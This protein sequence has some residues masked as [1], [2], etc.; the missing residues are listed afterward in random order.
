M[1][2][3]KQ[4][5]LFPIMLNNGLYYVGQWLL[6]NEEIKDCETIKLEFNL[7]NNFTFLGC[8][9]VTLYQ[10]L[11]KEILWITKVTQY[12]SVF[13]TMTTWKMSNLCN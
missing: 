12:I 5:S 1:L 8:N 3:E 6:N 13:S 7:E 4:R 11:E 9:W 10:Y 2:I